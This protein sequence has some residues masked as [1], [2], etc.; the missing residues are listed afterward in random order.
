[1]PAPDAAAAAKDGEG[2]RLRLGSRVL[3]WNDLEAANRLCTQV[4][5]CFRTLQQGL[6]ACGCAPSYHWLS[7]LVSICMRPS[8][9]AAAAPARV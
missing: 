2:C 8:F 4:R 3:T 9:L 7:V 6:N 1:M 5:L